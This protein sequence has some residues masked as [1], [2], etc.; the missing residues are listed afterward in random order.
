MFPETLLWTTVHTLSD[1]FIC[2]EW[3]ARGYFPYLYLWNLKQ[4]GIQK[5]VEYFDY[6]S[7]HHT[8]SYYIRDLHVQ[9]S[10][11]WVRIYTYILRHMVRRESVSFQPKGIWF[12]TVVQDAFFLL[13]ISLYLLNHSSF[14]KYLFFKK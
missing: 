6:V 3:Q 1:L 13:Y 12:K 5:S 7:I 8:G 11:Q 9:R 2:W 10:T 4:E 14:H